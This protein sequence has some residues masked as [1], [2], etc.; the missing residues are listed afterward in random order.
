MN[1]YNYQTDPEGILLK[2]V[3]DPLPPVCGGINLEYYFSRVDNERLGAGS[4]LPHN[5]N[6]LIGV[7]NSIDGDLRP[8]LPLQMVE[9]HDPVRLLILV[10]HFPEVVLRTIQSSESLYEWFLNEWVHLMAIQS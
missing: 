3:M 4:K 9:V 2:N 7:T 8:G 5:I 6:G 1:S 10:E